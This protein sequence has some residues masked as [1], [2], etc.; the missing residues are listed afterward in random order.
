MLLTKPVVAIA[1]VFD[2]R[3]LC[4]EEATYKSMCLNKAVYLCKSAQING[5]SGK[6]I[7]DNFTALLILY[8]VFNTTTAVRIDDITPIPKKKIKIRHVVFLFFNIS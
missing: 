3:W 4:N 1:S 2:R 8:G 6:S 7:R 5:F